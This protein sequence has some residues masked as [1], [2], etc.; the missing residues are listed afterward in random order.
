MIGLR[1]SGHKSP[2]PHPED[3]YGTGKD[4]GEKLVFFGID[5]VPLSLFRVQIRG[6]VTWIFHE[7][8]SKIAVAIQNSLVGWSPHERKE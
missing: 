3:C 8:S 4:G 1:C 6:Q 5:V 7:D 2:P